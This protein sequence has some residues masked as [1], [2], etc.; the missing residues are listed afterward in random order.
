M[1]EIDEPEK[2]RLKVN[3]ENKKLNVFTNGLFND[4]SAAGAY[5]VQMAEA[6]IGEKVYVVHFP[7]A[8]NFLSELLVA[9]YQK[10]LE[11]A[12]LGNTNATQEIINLSQIYGQDGLN[13]IGHS[14]GSM[15]IGNAMETLQTMGLVE[16][17]SNTN[18]K[19]VGPAYSAQEAANSLDTLSGGN[20]TS[21]ELQ[22]HMADFV[23]RLIGGNPAT[24][25]EVA[26]G[27]GLIK[28]WIKLFGAAPNVH[29]CYG[30][31]A[32]ST[33]CYPRYGVPITHDINSAH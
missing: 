18:I 9:G 28:E 23:G 15:T 10:G 22:N 20:Q 33:D 31:G 13:L 16:P 12:A 3:G 26:E 7:D 30:T 11:S 14:R 17:L 6:P 21:V 25:G 4:E 8:N 27:S 24:Y 5:S 29:G 19:F 32:A 2:F 1:H